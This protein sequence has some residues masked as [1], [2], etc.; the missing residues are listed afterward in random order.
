MITTTLARLPQAGSAAHA[1]ARGSE[2]R[3]EFRSTEKDLLFSKIDC[4]PARS[5][6]PIVGNLYVRKD[7]IIVKAVHVKSNIRLIPACVLCLE[8]NAKFE[9]EKLCKYTKIRQYK[10][11]GV[12]L[13]G[14]FLCTGHSYV[15]KNPRLTSL[16]L[17]GLQHLQL[18]K[19]PTE[20]P[21][22]MCKSD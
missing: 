7:G 14:L 3:F 10:K 15:D 20:L 17:V 1:G 18:D 8:N 6:N 21:K 12:Q 13:H 4:Q 9:Y 11:G 16:D 5:E 2:Y 22:R 19:I